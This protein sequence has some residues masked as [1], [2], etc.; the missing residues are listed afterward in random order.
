VHDPRPVGSGRL[1]FAVRVRCMPKVCFRRTIRASPPARQALA[2]RKGRLRSR[3]RGAGGQAPEHR[4]DLSIPG[5]RGRTRAL[6]QNHEG[7]RLVAPVGLPRCFHGCGRDRSGSVVSPSLR[8]HGSPWELTGSFTGCTRESSELGC[9]PMTSPLGHPQPVHGSP[10]R[11]T[12]RVRSGS[13]ISAPRRPL[14]SLRESH[15]VVHRT[16]T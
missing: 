9:R 5:R 6:L 13:V 11:R 15:Q 7:A 2:R 16:P 3:A 14:G 1:H 4:R 8:A 12:D 10:Q